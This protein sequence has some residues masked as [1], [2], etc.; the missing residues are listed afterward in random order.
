MSLLGWILIISIILIIIFGWDGFWGI[1]DEIWE[2]GTE[3]ISDGVARSEL[4][5]ERLQK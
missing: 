5:D 4:L 1:I 2:R 3:V